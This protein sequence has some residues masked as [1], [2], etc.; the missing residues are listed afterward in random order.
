MGL[1]AFANAVRNIDPKTLKLPAAIR[2]DNF[3]DKLVVATEICGRA[4]ESDK[5]RN[6]GGQALFEVGGLERAAFDAYGAMSRRRCQA[7]R[8][9]RTGRAIL[10]NI[11]VNADTKIPSGRS[12]QCALGDASLR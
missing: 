1:N 4:I 9:Q 5:G 8:W 12:F 10:A 3:Q 6:V 2:P 11:G 7:D